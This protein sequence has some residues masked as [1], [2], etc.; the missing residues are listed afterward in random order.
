MEKNNIENIYQGRF[1]GVWKD[2][3]YIFVD[4][5]LNSVTLSFHP[6]DWEMIKAEM[7]EMLLKDIKTVQ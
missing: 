6:D 7:Q 2:K 3:E 1:T 5:Y 4:F